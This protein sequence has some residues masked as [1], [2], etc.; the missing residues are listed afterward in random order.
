MLVF[1]TVLFAQVPP[2]KNTPDTTLIAKR[3]TIP[4]KYPFKSDQKGGLF[5]SDPSR[6]EIEF[7]PILG[8]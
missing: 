8:K 1:Q 7:D 6:S 3:D 4:L 2:V 5:L